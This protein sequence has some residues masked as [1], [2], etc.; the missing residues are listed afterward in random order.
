MHLSTFNLVMG[1]R[2]EKPNNQS[3][4]KLQDT[5]TQSNLTAQQFFNQRLGAIP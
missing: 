4:S 1:N 5:G 3:Y 2:K